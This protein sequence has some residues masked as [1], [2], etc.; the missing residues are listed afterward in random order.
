MA[1][2][3]TAAKKREFKPTKESLEKRRGAYGGQ[4][5]TWYLPEF[6]PVQVKEGDHCFRLL[7]PTFDGAEH[8]GIDLYLHSGIG[9]DQQ[10][11]LCPNKMKGEDCPICDEVRA[12]KKA[13]QDKYANEIRAYQRILVWA[14]DRDNEDAGPQLLALPVTVDKA[15]VT[16]SADRRTGEIFDV[17][18]VDD[19]YDVE[20]SREG[21]GLKTKYPNIAVARRPSPL[22]KSDKEIDR[23]LDF[24]ENNPLP[25]TLQFFEADYIKGVFEG[26]KKDPE[27]E[28][29]GDGDGDK[30]RTRSS[31]RAAKE[32]EE[33]PARSRGR[34]GEEE[35]EEEPPRRRRRTEPEEEDD[36][37]ADIDTPKGRSSR[38]A[39]EP[40][41]EEEEEPPRRV[42][43][44]GRQAEEEEKPRRRASREEEEEE[45]DAPP[46]RS[47][48]RAEPEDEPEEEEEPPRR[49]RRTEPEEEEE[50]EEEK[51]KGRAS[52]KEE[53]E[54]PRRSALRDKIKG[55]LRGKK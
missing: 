33:K 8:W 39:S 42:R 13:G 31:R 1:L 19:G 35:E 23:W 52:K 9:A 6:R 38:R 46:R 12:A 3:K 50:E 36:P 29:E 37:D 15:I 48:R 25:D 20:F 28:E 30:P 18:N 22:S 49:R 45:P 11:Y 16:L 55:G 34:R 51:P 4:Y 14:V 54:P 43:G 2:K 7:P 24:T 44:G 26:G 21:T 53:E 32:E 27:E 5:D 40:E 10:T 47:S 17:T 41:E